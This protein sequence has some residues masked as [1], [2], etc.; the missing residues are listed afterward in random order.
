M[1]IRLKF[2][3]RPVFSPVHKIIKL[4]INTYIDTKL[5]LICNCKPVNTPAI[6]TVNSG[7]ELLIVSVKLTGT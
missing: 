4:K 5:Y 1:G 7:A 6:I 3:Y 2:T